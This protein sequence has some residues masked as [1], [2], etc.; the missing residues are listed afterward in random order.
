MDDNNVKRIQS[1]PNY[2]K[3]VA[4]RKSYGWTLAI[5]M[6]VLYYG[7]IAV[8]AF[9]PASLAIKVAGVITTGLIAGFALIVISIVLTG[10]YVLR[11]NS[12]YDDLTAAI[13]AANASATGGKK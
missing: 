1:D 8:V 2:I 13:V 6:L 3:L 7:Y 5:L 4:E 12:S 11:A 10:I 9:A